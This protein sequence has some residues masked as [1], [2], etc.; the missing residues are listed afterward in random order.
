MKHTKQTFKRLFVFSVLSILLTGCIK[1]VTDP[2]D[3]ESSRPIIRDNTVYTA[4]GT[5]V[6]GSFTG[7]EYDF[8]HDRMITSGEIT[9]LKQNGLNALHVYLE[10]NYT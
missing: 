7:I 3:Q 8:S 5:L 2:K 9:T 4:N 1:E 6:R 10:N